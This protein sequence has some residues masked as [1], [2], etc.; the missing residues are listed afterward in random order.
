M[1]GMVGQWLGTHAADR[2]NRLVLCNTAA[3]HHQPGGIVVCA[4]LNRLVLCNTA[5]KI[6]SDT[7]WNERIAAVRDCGIDSIIPAVIGRWFTAD[8]SRTH[9]ASV[10]HT[11]AMLHAVSSEGY[12]A[13]CAAIRDMDQRDTVRSINTP[14]LV[15]FG[16]EDQ[17]TPPVQADF[18]MRNIRGA[19]G[20]GPNAAH[21]SNIEDADGFNA[22]VIDFLLGQDSEGAANG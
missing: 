1:G 16:F 11:A 8:S 14:T 18:L 21:L 5:A 6:G 2:L 15:V 9:A 17:V 12:T 3:K 13:S 4:R 20:L 7:G 10:A 19:R 22:G